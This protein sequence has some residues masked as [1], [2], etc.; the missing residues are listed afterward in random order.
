MEKLF[1]QF[2]K[3]QVKKS[4]QE[5]LKKIIEN[6]KDSYTASEIQALFTIDH[7]EV[8]CPM[9]CTVK[10]MCEN[11]TFV[12]DKN[13]SDN[14]KVLEKEK[15]QKCDICKKMSEHTID[16][17]FGQGYGATMCPKCAKQIHSE[18]EVSYNHK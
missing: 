8:E 1:N 16:A 10:C 3:K 15:L 6:E 4:L 11:D 2:S 17:Y 13:L 9:R 7:C 5:S 18:F 12:S 14:N